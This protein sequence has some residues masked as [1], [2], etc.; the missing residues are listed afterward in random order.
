MTDREKIISDDYYDLVT[1]YIHP[2]Q[3]NINVRDFVF[4][5]IEGEIGITYVN[6]SEA[7]PL[8]ISEY[9]YPVWPKVYGL[10][11]LQEGSG[12]TFDPTPLI[13]SGITQMQREPL[14]LTG[15]GV[16]IGF[17]DTGDGVNIMS[18]C[19]LLFQLFNAFL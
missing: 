6:R 11:Q 9:T 14:N 13:R 15:R 17:L 18:G 12:Q 19:L 3:G 4:Q 2:S 5:P 8:N 16:V 1:D 10:M 7:A